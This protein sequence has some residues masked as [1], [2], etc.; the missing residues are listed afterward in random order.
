MLNITARIVDSVSKIKRDDWD[1]VFK[2]APEGYPF[3][4]L[5]ESSCLREFSFHYLILS[6]G[7]GIVFIAPLFIADFNLDIAAGKFIA[8]GIQLLR[9]IFPRLLVV[10]TLFCGS[11]FGENGVAGV[12]DSFEHKNELI[13]ELVKGI[14]GFCQEKKI[15]LILFKDFL[16]K[17]TLF[18]DALLPYRFFKVKS[19]PCAV[20]QLGCF[21]SFDD[22]LSSLGSATRKNLRREIK[23]A[24]STAEISVKAVDCVGEIIEDIY[25]LYLNTYG[26]GMTK[27]E[28]LTPQFFLNAGKEMPGQA[29]FFLY[30]V[31]GRLAAF[32]L[33]F[34]YPDLFIDKFI[35]FDYDISQQVHLYYLS[36]CYNVEWC[37]K[38][39]ISSYQ[40]GQTDYGAKLK[41]GAKLIPLY[42]YLRHNS[43]AINAILA[44]LAKF[45]NPEKSDALLKDKL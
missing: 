34:V 3:Y 25:R 2:D 28:K 36:W 26:A 21:S 30:Y 24:Y 37:L 14:E 45:L 42:A 19:F 20:T 9:R 11:P 32:N 44:L 27:F 29:K 16:P 40:T 18:L 4:E 15:P 23:K 35:G 41:L 33:C 7:D 31:N 39:K 6:E 10:K 8:G 1:A 38:H 43:R 22:Y 12:R 17:E 5:L 13:A